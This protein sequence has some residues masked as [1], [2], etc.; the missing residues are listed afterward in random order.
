[1]TE[2]RLANLMPLHGGVIYG[3]VRSRRLGSSL[4]VNVLP[5]A[6]KRCTFNCPYCQYGWTASGRRSESPPP[7][8]PD[9]ATVVR[10]VGAA[11]DTLATR[12]VALDRLTLAGHGE[13]TLHPGFSEIVDGL[14]EL[15]DARAPGVGIAV[16]SNSSTA[17]LPAVRAALERVD[18]R[19]MKLDAGDQDTLRRVNASAVPIGRLVE[20]LASLPNVVLQTMFVSDDARGIDNTS[21]QAVGAWLRAVAA[22][23]PE[24][25]HLYTLDRRPAWS[26]LRA[27][28]PEFLAGIA[29]RVREMGTP[30]LVFG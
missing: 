21:E 2:P 25:V 20:A 22:I 9:P 26:Q 23:R 30:A 3:P 4:G 8:W 29:A 11:L 24:A 7:A 19:Y 6:E 12:G 18:E 28:T 14:R 17:H 27:V 15:R 5:P 16:L 1:M 13:P 10:E